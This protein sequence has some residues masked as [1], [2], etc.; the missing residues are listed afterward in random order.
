MNWT[1]PRTQ[2]RPKLLVLTICFVLCLLV[3]ALYLPFRTNP[4][5]FDDLNIYHWP[6]SF[7][8]TTPIGLALR[9][10]AYFSIAFVETIWGLIEVHRL[11]SLVLLVATGLALYM[12]LLRLLSVLPAAPMQS[13]NAFDWQR[14]L[15]AAAI[16]GLSM[17][18]PAAVYAAGYLIQRSIVLATLFTLLGLHYFL[19]GLQERRYADAVTAAVLSSLAILSKEHALMFPA[20]ALVALFVVR[21]G[22]W[23]FRLRFGGLYAILCLP[24]SLLVVLLSRQLI[25]KPYE[26]QFDSFAR[27]TAETGVEQPDWFDSVATQAVLFFRYLRTWLWPRVADMSVD[28]RVDLLTHQPT[29][30]GMFLITAFLAA[31]LVAALLVWRAQGRWRLIGFGLL[32]CWLLFLVDMSIV[33]VQEPFVIYRSYLWA[34][35]IAIMVVA[36]MQKVPVKVQTVAYV[37]IG[38]LLFIQAHDRL[39]TFS[40]PLL[41]WQD[42][43]AK[44]PSRPVLGDAR[45][46]SNLA[47]EYVLVGRADDA[48]ATIGRCNDFYPDYYQ[49]AFARGAIHLFREDR[50]EYTLARDWLEQA[51]KLRPESAI[52][53]HH[54]G[55]AYEKLD[56]PAAAKQHY[57][58]ASRLGFI[59]GDLRQQ[60]MES[61]SGIITIYRSNKTSGTK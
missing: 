48:I 9:L 55:L 19:R 43:A 22:Q 27:R 61:T 1:S 36:V 18:H 49:C 59:G 32:Y 53:R 56:Q 16:A 47:R 17:I 5:V 25:M 8:A 14:H 31:A 35:G 52:A 26:L 4:L 3:A 45:I 39:M 51:V 6:L 34:P 7:Y 38:S 57:A 10:P 37:A 50:D 40:H 46:Y 12:V 15:P 29:A 23:S 13:R 54:L 11:V 44:L 41:L 60:L 28:T 30:M 58:E 24:A 33:R 42:A 2:S 20:V 21:E